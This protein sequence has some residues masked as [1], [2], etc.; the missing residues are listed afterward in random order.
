M[1]QRKDIA[2]E[3]ARR[4]VTL[5]K[6]ALD[7]FAEILV[8]LKFKRGETP[9]KE[10]DVCDS[11]YYIE[12]GLTRQYY[13][14]NGKEVTEHLEYE[15]GIV[16]CIESFFLQ[17]P[18]RLVIETLEPSK[19]YAIPYNKLQELTRTSYEFCQLMFSFLE[20]SLILSQRKADTL[21]FESAKERYLRTLNDHPDLVRR[22]PLHYLASYLQMTP[23]TLSR[24]RKGNK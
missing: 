17:E 12:K 5:S 15:G 3:I 23:E 13:V 24:V 2:R 11:L 22:A 18:S 20:H 9:V 19:I 16:M 10:G 21:R 7:K 4:Y 1:D 6:D 14:K 8:P